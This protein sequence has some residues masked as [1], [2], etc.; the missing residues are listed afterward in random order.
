MADEKREEG[1]QEGTK[2]SYRNLFNKETGFPIMVNL[3]VIK[4]IYYH[5]EKAACFLEKQ[6][7][8]KK[9]KANPIYQ[10]LLPISRQRFDRINKGITFEIS[11]RE[12][13]EI[14][15]RFGIG[16][17]YFRKE[18]PVMFSISGLKEEDWKRFYSAHYEVYE[19]IEKEEER[20]RYERK[21]EEALK[22]LVCGDW[23]TK[24]DPTDPLFAICFYFSYGVRQNERKRVEQI[25]QLLEE[26]DYREW[27]QSREIAEQAYR[28]LKKHYEYTK[29]L[30]I[31]EHA[32]N[33]QRKKEE[34]KRKSIERKRG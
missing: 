8:G 30:C 4:Y 23:K 21:V 27:E 31:I 7:P 1:K 2:K 14:T 17:E 12:V 34:K 33:E 13:R 15:E 29:S 19:K 18:N 32:R 10:F 6:E 11:S 26:M 20:E 3:Y 22:E 24:L 25:L 5:I 28:L 9:A 16:A